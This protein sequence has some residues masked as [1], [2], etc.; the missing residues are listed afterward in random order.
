M[1][2]RL[3]RNFKANE[4]V[5]F[6]FGAIGFFF[7][8]TCPIL[9]PIAIITTFTV[10]K[11]S[12]AGEPLS[13]Q[14]AISMALENNPS[15]VASLEKITQGEIETRGAYSSLY[16]ELSAVGTGSRKKAAAHKV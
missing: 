6:G 2:T 13:L 7:A 4:N 11:S 16:P 15:R 12:A 10:Q 9:I 8:K 1:A 5:D 3:F 14:K